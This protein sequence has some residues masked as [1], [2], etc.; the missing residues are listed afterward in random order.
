M[1]LRFSDRLSREMLNVSVTHD[2]RAECACH[3]ILIVKRY[4]SLISSGTLIIRMISR[5]TLNVFII[6]EMDTELYLKSYDA[7]V[8]CYLFI[9]SSDILRLSDRSE[10]CFAYP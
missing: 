9:I 8:K 5:G 6:Y 3:V 7:F 10:E 4:L 1:H 2:K